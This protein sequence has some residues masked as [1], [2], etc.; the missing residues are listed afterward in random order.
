[1]SEGLSKEVLPSAGTLGR[2]HHPH[3][4]DAPERTDVR[5]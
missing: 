2:P 3:D 1:M 4:G 5:I